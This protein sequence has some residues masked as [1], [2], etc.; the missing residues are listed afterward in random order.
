MAIMDREFTRSE[1]YDLV[2]TRPVKSV[3][4]DIGISDVALVKHCKK[5]N[6]PVPGRGYWARKQ[7]GKSTVQIPLP[8]RFAGA[9]DRIGGAKE[10]YYGS[11]WPKKFLETPVPPVP[12][13]DE[14]LQVVEQRIRKI[15]GKVTCSRKFEPAHP[16][17]SKLLVHDEERR[18]AFAKWGS[19]YNA[20]RYDSGPER[21]RLLITNGLFLAA[22]RLGCRPSMGTSKYGQDP[23]SERDL[24]IQIGVSWVYFSIEPVKSKKEGQKERL[25]LAFGRARDRTTATKFWEDNEAEQLQDQMSEIMV[26]MLTFAETAY[27]DRLV[28]QRDWI[29]ERKIAAEDEIRRRQ[30]DAE[31]KA[32]ESEAKLAKERVDLLLS[33]AESLERANRIR[34]YVDGVLSRAPASET[35]KTYLDNWAVWALEQADQIDPLKNGEFHRSVSSI[36]NARVSHDASCQVSAWRSQAEEG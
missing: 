36:G 24:C 2:W 20:P 22:R 16:L 3:A 1:F 11:D 32:R 35:E 25:R 21:R 27:R 23:G 6:I 10:Q 30:E 8:P 14:E 13:F 31:R 26:G 28:K 12:I 5:A 4:A 34:I 19:H 17:V 9:S 33:Q 29:I 18:Q 7:A 15:V